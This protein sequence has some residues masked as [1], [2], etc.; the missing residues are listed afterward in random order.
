MY[1]TIKNIA[2]WGDPLQDAITQAI[3]VAQQAT[4]VALM[5]DHHV[6]YAMPIGGVAA[7]EGAISPSGAGYDIGC[8]N[9]AVLLDIP[10]AEVK[11]SINQIM[12]DIWQNISFGVGRKNL[13]PVEDALFD[14]DPAW[15]LA[16]GV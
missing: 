13:L 8:G 1:Q 14:D 6:G 10:A 4:A 12:D 15:E 2:V 11:N 9:K 16:A 3:T 7:Y 5:A